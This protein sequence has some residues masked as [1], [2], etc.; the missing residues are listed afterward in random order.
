MTLRGWLHRTSSVYLSST[1]SETATMSMQRHCLSPSLRSRSG[2]DSAVL[3]NFVAPSLNPSIL[4]FQSHSAGFSS[5]TTCSHGNLQ[6]IVWNQTFCRLSKPT[7]S[8]YHSVL[9][10]AF[11]RFQ[12]FSWHYIPMSDLLGIRQVQ[13]TSNCVSLCGSNVSKMCSFVE[14]VPYGNACFLI[15]LLVTL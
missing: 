10:R 11:M 13:Q 5:A 12:T 9:Q 1:V 4:R 14:I 6:P 2:G 3:C 8:Y 15:V 7:N